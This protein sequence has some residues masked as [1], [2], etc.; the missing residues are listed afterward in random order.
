M[1]CPPGE[2]AAFGAV[3]LPSPALDEAT[4]DVS[5]V[6]AEPTRYEPDA[7]PSATDASDVELA[8][9][10]IE[11]SAVEQTGDAASAL[12][13]AIPGEVR[14]TEPEITGSDGGTPA[15]QRPGVAAPAADTAARPDASSDEANANAESEAHDR[16]TATTTAPFASTGIGTDSNADAGKPSIDPVAAP[17]P[18]HKPDQPQG[19][20][21]A[22]QPQVHVADPLEARFAESNHPRIVTA[23]QSE[24]MP[25]GGTVRLRLDP[26]E[27][28]AL[29]VR[30]DVRDGVVAAS[31]QTSNDE[32]AR[33][34]TQSL[35]RLKT[36]LESQGV[37]VEKLHVQ[38]TPREQ[39]DGGRGGNGD[40]RQQHSAQHWQQQE[41]QRREMLQRMW[42]RVRDGRDP[43]DLVA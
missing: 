35:H 26:P 15:R 1:Q 33:L 18:G 19:V 32:A 38:Q 9:P 25:S 17:P 42:R 37:S 13:V 14:R 30:I 8:D 4:L 39:W 3:D 16:P 10:A 31:F 29:Q 2:P 11:Q 20:K 40:E 12:S 24:L 7:T 36:T 22:F 23:V 27:L 5:S 28:G 41:Q 21:V 6:I 34:L 43:F